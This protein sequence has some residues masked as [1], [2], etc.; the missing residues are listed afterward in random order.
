MDIL[1][2][3]GKFY[4]FASLMLMHQMMH[5]EEDGDED[6]NE[7][8]D[9]LTGLQDGEE[10]DARWRFFAQWS[11]VLKQASDKQHTLS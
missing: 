3:P 5:K 9:E 6:K 7:D 8:K 4:N 10:N 11:G 2:I 1:L